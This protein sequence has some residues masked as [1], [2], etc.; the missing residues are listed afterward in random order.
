VN[1]TLPRRARCRRWN[2]QGAPGHARLSNRTHDRHG[3]KWAGGIREVRA[4]KAP[5][6]EGRAAMRTAGWGNRR[7]LKLFDRLGWPSVGPWG[8][9]WDVRDG[10]AG[11]HGL[12]LVVIGCGGGRTTE[13]GP[14]QRRAC[15]CRPSGAPCGQRFPRSRRSWDARASCL[16]RWPGEERR[17]RVLGHGP[18]EFAQYV[19]HLKE[20]PATRVV[21]S[22]PVGAGPGEPTQPRP[23]DQQIRAPYVTRIDVM[24]PEQPA[25]LRI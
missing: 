17:E 18:L 21:V 3:K 4:K 9:S 6:G 11:Q 16:P 14:F 20:P 19:H 12:Y 15:P 5:I 22:S 25:R 1:E 8:N 24:H 23:R 2:G 10:S 7:A 13:L